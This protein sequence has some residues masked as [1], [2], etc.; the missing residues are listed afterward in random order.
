MNKYDIFKDSG[1]EWI[2]KIPEHWQLKKLKHIV[3][4]VGSGVTPKG[5]SEVYQS[6]GVPFLRSQNIHFGGIR[7]D[8]VAYISEEIDADMAGSRVEV[9]DVLLNITGASIGRCCYVD[10]SFGKGNVNQHVCIIRPHEDRIDHVFLY[11]ILRSEVGQHQIDLQQTGAN[12]EGLNFEQLRNFMIPFPSGFEQKIISEF[13]SGKNSQIDSLIQKKQQLI[14]LL[15][16]EKTAVINEA[17][18]KGL[19]S[20]APMKDSGIERLGSIPQHWKINKLKHL[21][22]KIGDGIHATPSYVDSSGIY[23]INGTNLNNGKIKITSGTRCVDEEEYLKHKIG[24]QKGAI[25]LSLNGTIGKLAFYN[26]EKVVLGK[27]AAY[28][29]CTDELVNTFAYYFLQTA[30]VENYFEES[31]SG[32]TINNLSLYTLRNTPFV[33]PPKPE[34]ILIAEHITGKIQAL[35]STLSHTYH[36]IELLQEYRTALISG[37][38]TGKIDVRDYQPKPESEAVSVN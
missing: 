9:G 21:T 22:L 31:F 25:L 16:E 23:F 38:V 34:Q 15:E 13:L 28:I 29:Q 3:K 10:S 27:S 32:S 12:R 26:D 2:G 4:K 35:E 19:N 20:D 8:D 5:G 14:A 1:I 6:Y 24:I 33:V 37:A 11:Y 17:V 7:L 36:Q 18:T 30:L